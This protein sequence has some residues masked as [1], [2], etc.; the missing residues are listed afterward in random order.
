MQNRFIV[1]F[2]KESEKLSSMCMVDFKDAE[3]AKKHIEADA[4]HFCQAHRGA[5]KL[6]WKDP[7][8][9]D[10]FAVK[11]RGGKKCFW[12]YFELPHYGIN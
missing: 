12:Q 9:T 6:G 2:R 7:D 11:L 4:E 5:K 10:Y 8:A 3:A 1:M